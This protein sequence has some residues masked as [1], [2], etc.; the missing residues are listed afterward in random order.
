MVMPLS[1]HA[2]TNMLMIIF[3]TC[4]TPCLPLQLLACC[5]YIIQLIV[6]FNILKISELL[7][8]KSQKT[9]TKRNHT[10]HTNE[11]LEGKIKRSSHLI[12]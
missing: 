5:P 4:K 2:Y 7:T 12:Q 9:N 1:L 6:Q 3:L 8:N 11:L 10:N